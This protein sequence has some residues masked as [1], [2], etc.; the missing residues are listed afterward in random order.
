MDSGV[1]GALN[2]DSAAAGEHAERYYSFIR[3]TVADIPRIAENTGIAAEIIEKVKNYLFLELHD[4]GGETK[5]FD[6]SYEIAQ[7]WQRL[8]QGKAIL[9]HDLTLIR[10]ESY[11]MELT[12]S[13]VPQG[14]AH[15]LASAKYN[16][17]KEV[18]DYHASL[19]KH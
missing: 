11:E 18:R 7:S 15:I 4:L 2:A 10:H 3:T 17:S 12:A 5:R 6:P 1:F 8:W 14:K 19:N 13:G 9:N 16:Y